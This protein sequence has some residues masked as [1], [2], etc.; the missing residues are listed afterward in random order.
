LPAAVDKRRSQ[1]Q[2]AIVDAQVSRVETQ[3]GAISYL[4]TSEQL[5][6]LPLNGRNFEQLSC[7][8]EDAN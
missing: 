1:R 7:F 3:T 2:D 8:D 4:V 5:D 6:N